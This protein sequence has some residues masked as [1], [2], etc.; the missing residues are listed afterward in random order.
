MLKQT[1]VG[2]NRQR[3]MGTDSTCAPTIKAAFLRIHNY[4]AAT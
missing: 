2:G 3:S 1:E 4:V